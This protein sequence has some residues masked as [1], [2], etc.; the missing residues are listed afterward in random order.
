MIG[1]QLRKKLSDNARRN[2]VQLVKVRE[3]RLLKKTLVIDCECGEKMILL[4]K[5]DDWR[6]GN[7]LLECGGCEDR[8]MLL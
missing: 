4:G 2:K 5:E 6:W 8:F 3:L 7:A 1:G